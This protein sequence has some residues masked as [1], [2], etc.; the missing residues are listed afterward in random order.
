MICF[1]PQNHSMAIQNNWLTVITVTLH[2]S[3]DYCKHEN[4][5][6]TCI[7]IF[8]ISISKRVFGDIFFFTFYIT[9]NVFYFNSFFFTVRMTH[10][11]NVFEN[12]LQVRLRVHN[13]T[14]I[15]QWFFFLRIHYI[16]WPYGPLE[17]Y[18]HRPIHISS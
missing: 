14:N 4:K 16:F 15:S 17:D 12:K 7:Y 1:Y 3:R 13:D 2:P 6:N 5:W 9:A 18:Q 8:E 10:C 11:F